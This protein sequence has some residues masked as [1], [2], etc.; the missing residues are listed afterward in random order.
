LPFNPST[1][2]LVDLEF[3]EK[4]LREV[5]KRRQPTK[6]FWC[7]QT[8][9]FL[10]QYPDE[11]IDR[12]FTV[13]EDTPRHTHQVLTKRAD[14]MQRYCARRYRQGVPSNIWCGVSCG[15][16]KDGLPRL[17]ALRRVDAAVRF[18]SAEPLLEDLGAVDLSGLHWLILGGESRQRKVVRP[19]DLIWL[20]SF[21]R[22]GREQGVA[23]FVKQLGSR[24]ELNGAPFR[25]KS[26]K[27]SKP[28][29]WPDDLRVREMPEIPLRDRKGC[30][31]LAP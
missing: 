6:W 19:C 3:E 18:V 31:M 15:N 28:E 27:G 16:I 30:A 9:M 23:V 24:A 20:R 17:D 1:L 22:Q 29:E 26:R 14:R 4:A 5:L 21:V 8:D 7:D 2:D 11:W 12:C 13:M 10:A 25:T